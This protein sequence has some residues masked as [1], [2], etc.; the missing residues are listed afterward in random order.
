MDEC[1]RCGEDEIG[2]PELVGRFEA[3]FNSIE[4]LLRSRHGED[5]RV[6]FVQLLEMEWPGRQAKNAVYRD[7]RRFADL[8]NTLIHNRIDRE[9][10]FAIPT[11]RTVFRIESILNDL[12][13][14]KLAIPLFQRQVETLQTTDT[15]EQV[16][17]RINQ[18]GI[19]QFPAYAGDTFE[20][21]LTRRGILKWLASVGLNH[22]SDC[23][24]LRSVPVGVLLQSEEHPENHRFIPRNTPLMKMG[25]MIDHHPPLETLLI[26]QNGKPTEKL[27]GIANRLD[28]H[29]AI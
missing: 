5:N 25:E 10:D 9:H 13:E 21:V 27:L 7:L 3:A 29:A 20:G 15:L 4:Q 11:P 6:S 26:T 17:N 19:S 12:G 18:T 8:R 28:I 14:V 22:G 24:G 1:V 2:F 16:L 23:A